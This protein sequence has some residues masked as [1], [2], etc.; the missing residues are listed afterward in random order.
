MTVRDDRVVRDA[1]E[2]IGLA[3]TS[4]NAGAVADLWDVP[5]L[6][7]ADQGVRA[8]GS[9]AEVAAFFEQ[10]IHAYRERGTPRAV[11]DDVRVTWVT[12][13]IAAVSVDWIGRDA[14]GGEREREGSFYLMRV[15]DDGVARVQVAM[16]RAGG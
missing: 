12:D 8:I 3:L 2:R 15:G 9:R 16:G 1:L 5:G 11:P 6:V 13:R 10:A 4:G 7:L 14:Q